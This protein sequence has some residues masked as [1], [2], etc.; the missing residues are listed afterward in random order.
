M[1]SMLKHHADALVVALPETPG[2]ENL[3]AHG[4]AHRQSGEDEVIQAR[5]HRGTQLIGAEVAQKRGVGKGDDGLRQVTQHDGVSNAPD[6]LICNSSFE[7]QESFF[8][9]KKRIQLLYQQSHR[10][11]P[12]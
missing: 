12:A 11:T 3:D 1:R 9:I 8:V 4:K 10:N 2:D 7:H 5:H 6:F